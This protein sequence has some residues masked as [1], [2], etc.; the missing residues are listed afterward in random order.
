[1]FHINQINP[2]R[3]EWIDVAITITTTL[4]ETNSFSR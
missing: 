4:P 2:P 1:M 3:K